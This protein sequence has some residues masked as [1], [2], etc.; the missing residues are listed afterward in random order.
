M[1]NSPAP[2]PKCLLSSQSSAGILQDDIHL[3]QC[4]YVVD[5]GQLPFL[6]FTPP[7]SRTQPSKMN[8]HADQLPSNRILLSQI[9]VISDPAIGEP[10]MG[11]WA[12]APLLGG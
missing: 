1:V 11:S 9:S 12:T 6:A 5:L 4:Y 8:A 7:T 3:T 10:L 2:S